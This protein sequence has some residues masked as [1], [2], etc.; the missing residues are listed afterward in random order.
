MKSSLFSALL[1]V[2]SFDFS[3]CAIEATEGSRETIQWHLDYFIDTDVFNNANYQTIGGPWTRILDPA[4][5]RIDKRLNRILQTTTE[6]G[7]GSVAYTL[8]KTLLP[9]E[10]PLEIVLDIGKA[11]DDPGEGGFPGGGKLHAFRAA[12]LIL[13]EH[14]I[15]LQNGDTVI[16]WAEVTPEGSAVHLGGELDEFGSAINPTASAPGDG[17]TIDNLEEGTFTRLVLRI[18]EDSVALAYHSGQPEELFGPA[19]ETT[20][21]D[22]LDSDYIELA[23]IE[24]AVDSAIDSVRFATNGGRTGLVGINTIA[25]FGRELPTGVGP[26]IRGDVNGDGALD[27]ADASF[28]FNYLFLGGEGSTCVS[29]MNSNAEDGPPNLTA[30]VFLLNFLFMGGSAPPAPYPEC[31]SSSLQIDLDLGCESSSACN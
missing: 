10:Y 21:F 8:P 30:G 7:P 5:A 9:G 15:I 11:G 20:N 2:A 22:G 23:C 31:D 16:A 25:V 24:Q 28:V 4:R 14:Q 17:I 26:F 3:P 18:T 13:P 19:Y 29:A 12:G 6:D 1:L 27:I